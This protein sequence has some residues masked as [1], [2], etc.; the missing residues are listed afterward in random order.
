[1]DALEL[2]E[3]MQGLLPRQAIRAKRRKHRHRAPKPLDPG[4]AEVDG[5]DASRV[6]NTCST[7]Q[8][9]NP[10]SAPLFGDRCLLLAVKGRVP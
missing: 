4:R 10:A 3:D 6:G 8:D 9:P 1:L 2:G 5:V 7:W